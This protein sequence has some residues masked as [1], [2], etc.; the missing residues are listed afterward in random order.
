MCQVQLV[1]NPIASVESWGI[2]TSNHEDNMEHVLRNLGPIAVGVDGADPTFLAYSGGIFDSSDCEQG[3]NHALLIVGYGQ[4]MDPR[5]DGRAMIKYWIA[6]NSWGE[7]WGENG[8]VR[9]KR[10][11]GV[12]GAAGVCGIAKSPSV[13]LGGALLRFNSGIQS[14]TTTA[15]SAQQYD[16]PS[17]DESE[18]MET[19]LVSNYCDTI[20]LGNLP[21]CNRLEGYVDRWN[22]F[23][24][25]TIVL[26]KLTKV[27]CI[28]CQMP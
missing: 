25:G 18:R 8:Y 5:N 11:S 27:V 10:N 7:G 22:C 19:S 16:D 12:K 14:T 1:A 20:G 4:E 2:L 13:A 23:G 17:Q 28:I 26:L 3:A 15:N 24:C 21:F 9:V 6:R